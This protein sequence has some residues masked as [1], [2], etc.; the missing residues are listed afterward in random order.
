[1][2]SG[3]VK[4]LF[5]DKEKTEALFPRTKT[6]AVSNEDGIGLDALMENLIYSSNENLNQDTVPLNADTL[7]GYPAEDYASKL[8]VKVQILKVQEGTGVD[9]SEFAT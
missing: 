6:S 4:T 9:L 8:Y 5:S 3:K 7:G 2:T 1:M